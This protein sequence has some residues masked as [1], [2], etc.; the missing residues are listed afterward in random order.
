MKCKPKTQQR[1]FSLLYCFSWD[2]FLLMLLLSS[3]YTTSLEGW[4]G[5]SCSLMWFFISEPSVQALQ[6]TNYPKLLLSDSCPWPLQNEV[7]VAAVLP[8]GICQH[9]ENPATD[10]L[11]FPLAV[12]S[13]MERN[14]SSHPSRI[15][16]SVHLKGKDGW[17]K[18]MS[19][20]G[21]WWCCITGRTHLSSVDAAGHQQWPS[22]SRD[23][24]WTHFRC[25]GWGRNINS[26]VSTNS[27]GQLLATDPLWTSSCPE[28]PH[29]GL[30][31]V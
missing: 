14:L 10:C 2:C 27:H 11:G 8:V 24:T 23:V 6:D 3:T 18:R 13:F 21:W 15:C 30:E 20:Q 26:V 4:G 22:G 16:S 28:G 7:V 1:Q 5:N 19:F 31:P 9:P 25:A 12:W 29:V 17:Q